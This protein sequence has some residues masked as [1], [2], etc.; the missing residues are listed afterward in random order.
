MIRYQPDESPPAPLAVGLGFQQAALCIAGIVLTPVIVI[1]AA[2]GGDDGYLG[3]AVFRR[4]R[5]QR[6]D[7]HPAGPSRRSRRRRISAAHGYFRGIHRRLR[8]RPGRGRA[9][10]AGGLGV[11]VV[12]ISVRAVRAPVLGATGHHADRRRYRDHAHRGDRHADHLRHVEGGARR[13]VAGRGT[14]Q[15]GADAGRRRRL[16]VARFRG[17]ATLGAS[18]RSCGGLR[19]GGVVW[20]LRR[21]PEWR[22]RTGL[23]CRSAGRGST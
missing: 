6:R 20:S 5:D 13:H 3:W 23:A 11:G 18:G 12:A 21:R 2:G 7:H 15:C 4:A 14:A 10:H 1:R 22:R 19:R 16:G 9:G 8:D 17:A